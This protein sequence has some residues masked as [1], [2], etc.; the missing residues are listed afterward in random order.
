MRLL[1]TMLSAALILA[2]VAGATPGGVDLRLRQV[3]QTTRTVTLAWNRHPSADGYEFTLNGVVVSRIFDPAVTRAIFWK[4]S[5]YGVQVLWRRADGRIVHGALA[6]LT[7]ARA[8]IAKPNIAKPRTKP[9]KARVKRSISRPTTSTQRSRLVFV[10]APKVAFKLRLASQT[11][12]KVTFAWK[13]QPGIDGYRFLR[14]GVI[15]SRTFDPSARTATFW[16]G[17]RYAVDLLRVMAG[18]RVKPV[19]RALAVA[20][21][22]KGRQRFVFLATPTINFKLRLVSETAKTITFAW[23]RQLGID[24]FQ[25]VRNGVVVSRTFKR[26]TTRATFWKG[27]HYAVELLRVSADKRVTRLTRA[28]AYTTPLSGKASAKQP[29]ASAGSTG[30]SGAGSPGGSGAGSA[31]GSPPPPSSSPPPPPPS[32]PPPPPPPPPPSSPPP[33]PAPPP[34]PPS[35]SGSYPDASTT[36]P[37]SATLV[38]YLGPTTITVPGTVIE[39]KN[40]LSC[41]TVSAS[42]VVIRNSRISCSD[43]SVVWSGGTNLV[44]EDTEIVCGGTP[45]TTGLTPEN[46][47]ARRV[48]ASRCENIFWAEHNVVIVDSYLHDPIPCCGAGDPHTDSVQVPHGASNITIRHN[49][50]Y[51]GY[52]NQSNFGNSAITL[53]PG[54]SNVEVDDNLLAGGGYTLYCGGEGGSSPPAEGTNNAFTNNRFTRALVSTVGGFGTMFDCADE[55]IRGNVIHETGMPVR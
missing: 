50:I 18:G 17:R 22:A 21:T 49:R 40:I 7:T 55:N 47:T 14:N 24:G 41:I 26:S 51:G 28:M 36:G 43:S 3:D 34:P 39:G 48:E 30:G 33:P 11:P 54:T 44:V 13:R 53:G 10:A 32:S 45:A 8:N 23:K 9:S 37:D 12:R 35:P 29:S 42:N 31:A 25:F 5:R 38:P 46:Y 19:R 6:T 52:I 15:V 2:S 27:S 1:L 16:K 20:S 4:G